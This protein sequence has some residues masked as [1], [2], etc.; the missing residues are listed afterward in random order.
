VSVHAES[1][2]LSYVQQPVSQ[3]P[4]NPSN[5]SVQLECEVA[6]TSEEQFEFLWKTKSTEGVLDTAVGAEPS[7]G[8]TRAR[9]VLALSAED[10][11]GLGE[12]YCELQ[13]SPPIASNVLHLWNVSS[14][15]LCDD[16][17]FPLVNSTPRC[18]QEFERTTPTT[19][20]TNLYRYV[21]YVIAAVVLLFAILI[22]IL[23]VAVVI[24]F[25]KK[26]HKKPSQDESRELRETKITQQGGFSN[27][28]RRNIAW[29]WVGFVRLFMTLACHSVVNGYSD[30][31]SVTLSICQTEWELE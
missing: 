5:E 30:I 19:P 21:L 8:G 29:S 20:P 27:R 2:S 26:C 4:C 14:L 15:P 16:S 9:T 1:C 3:L 18:I 7:S 24:L 23:V 12:V 22:V 13:L 6:S 31:L 25:Y 11:A 10:L 28:Y 17:Y